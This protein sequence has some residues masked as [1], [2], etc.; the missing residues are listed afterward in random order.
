MAGILLVPHTADLVLIL[1]AVHLTIFGLF[2]LVDVLLGS[3]AFALIG[4]L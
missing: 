2:R 1:L 4:R 3:L